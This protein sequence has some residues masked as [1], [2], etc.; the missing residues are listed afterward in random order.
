MNLTLRPVD[1]STNRVDIAVLFLFVILP[2]TLSLNSDARDSGILQIGVVGYI[3]WSAVKL[4]AA[5][6]RIPI[7]VRSVT[8]PIY[9]LAVVSVLSTMANEWYRPVVSYGAFGGFVLLALWQLSS[10]RAPGLAARQ[11]ANLYLAGAVLVLAV[12]ASVETPTLNRYSGLFN[13][14]NSMGWFTGGTIALCSGM[15]ASGLLRRLEAAATGVVLALSWLALLAS[16]SRNALGGAGLASAF[17]VFYYLRGL[18][19]SAHRAAKVRTL[20]CVATV[21]IGSVVG[22]AF[23][24]VFVPVL[25]KFGEVQSRGDITQGRAEGWAAMLRDWNLLGHGADYAA[26]FQSA[27]HGHNT[28]LTHLAQF[29]ALPAFLYFGILFYF[30]NYCRKAARRDG[31]GTGVVAVSVLA[32]YFFMAMFE[33]GSAVPAVWLG[34]VFFGLTA[35]GRGER[36]SSRGVVCR[37]TR[38]RRGPVDRH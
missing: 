18:S 1:Q 7:A 26:G 16:N 25:E 6:A 33:S 17:S 35:A 23:A 19:S 24:G 27:V 22:G 10:H 29:G 5:D 34:I 13:N 20:A 37:N 15:L 4:V 14:A 36:N 12:S 2:S 11:I 30:W 3:F 31:G 9:G 32:G 28:Y 8:T 38:D 21:G